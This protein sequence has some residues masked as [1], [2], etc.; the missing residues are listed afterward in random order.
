MNHAT[1]STAGAGEKSRPAS[2]K[3][4]GCSR[5]QKPKRFL[6]TEPG[7]SCFKGGALQGGERCV[8]RKEGKPG[9]TYRMGVGTKRIAKEVC[10]R[11][12]HPRAPSYGEKARN[13]ACF[14]LS[15]TE[16]KLKHKGNQGELYDQ[17]GRKGRRKETPKEDEDA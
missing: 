16:K 13:C 2:K 8:C 17:G 12:R 15:K 14:N 9:K 5:A 6:K 10:R 4:K 7:R 1:I 3:P 11:G